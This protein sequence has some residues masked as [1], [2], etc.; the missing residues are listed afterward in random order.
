MG[1][2]SFSLDPK[3]AKFL[4]HELDISVFIETGTFAGDTIAELEPSFDQLVSIEIDDDLY[5]K[6]VSRF[7]D[8]RKVEILQGDSAQKL[9][10]IQS[11]ITDRSVMY[12]LDAHWCEGGGEGQSESQ[13]P[14]LEEIRSIKNLNSRSV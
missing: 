4:K 6:A 5:A 13:C 2:I 10:E 12:W 1:A 11:Q 8:S 9:L 14:L 7:A 3:L